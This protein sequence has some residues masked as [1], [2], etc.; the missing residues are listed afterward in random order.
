[1]AGLRDLHLSRARVIPARM[2]EVRFSRSSGP[3]GQN[4]NKVSSK[5]EL[6][7][8][9]AQASEVLSE[10]ALSRIREELGNRIDNDGVLHIV[11]QEHREQAR[12]IDAALARLETLLKQ[13]LAPKKTR[14][15]TKP[16]RASKRR[17]VDDKKKRGQL[18]KQR[19]QRH[20]D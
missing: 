3:G 6:L 16:T 1:M 8:D 4:V 19:G 11:S 13:A 5:V 20:D 18:K 7:L 12:N 9:L 14:R 2:L 17:R 10:Y 15:A